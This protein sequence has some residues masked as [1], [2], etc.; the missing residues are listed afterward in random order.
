MI[1]IKRLGASSSF[2]T[3]MCS[4]P[5]KNIVISISCAQSGF[6]RKVK[7]IRHILRRRVLQEKEEAKDRKFV[8]KVRR[9]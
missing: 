6:K 7:C 9:Q 4:I 8:D 1:N 2:L 5:N 3:K